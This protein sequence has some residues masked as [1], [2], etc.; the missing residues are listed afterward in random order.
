MRVI[1]APDSFKES[2]S[3]T[4]A[5]AAMARGV[6]AAAAGVEVDECPIADGGEGTVEAMLAATR[7]QIHRSRVTGPLGNP[8]EGA[9]GML[10]CTVSQPRTAV[11]EMAA[12]SGLGLV[13][14]DQRDPWQTT[15]F[16][17]GELLRAALDAGAQRIILGVGGSATNDGGC[18]AAQALGVCFYDRDGLLIEPP[19]TGG[20][21]DRIGRIVVSGIDRRLA[22][23]ELVVACDVTNPL[24]GPKGAAQVYGPQKGASPE[25]VRALDRALA[26]VAVLV[27]DQL[28]VDVADLP[29]A[30]A[31]GGLGFA[32][33][34][35]LAGQLRRGV[36]LVLEAVGF[37]RRVSGCDVCLTGEGRIDGQTLSGKAIAGVAAAAGAAGVPTLALVGCIGPG[38]ERAPEVGIRS[39]SVI[40]ERLPR[41]ESMARAAELLESTAARVILTQF[42]FRHG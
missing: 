27:R 25:Q 30:G 10:G 26:H 5:A 16:G 34:A 23:T 39:V 18:G 41:D 38:A 31:A 40:G 7:G 6:A 29:G 2:L 3:A 19:V 21:L 22:Q 4:E 14:A 13:P 15:T 35:L 12:A 42:S 24:T 20:M 37:D 32:A 17:T 28:D 8:V 36:E 1:C 11:I 33:V 9:W